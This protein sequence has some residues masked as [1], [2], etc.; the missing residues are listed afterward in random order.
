MAETG[1]ASGSVAEL[2]ELFRKAKSARSG[3]IG[4]WFLNTSYYAGQQWSAYQGGRVIDLHTMSDRDLVTDNRIMPVVTH[5]V[6]RKV[7]NRPT[8]YCTPYTGDDS[9]TEAARIG[10]SVLEA[11]WDQLDLQNKLFRACLWADVCC[12]GFWKIFWDPTVGERGDFLFSNDGQ[13]LYNPQ[14]QTPLR[15]EE[16]H[17]VPPDVLPLTQVQSV[18]DGD[19]VVEV[20]SPFELFPD[21][22]ATGLED[23]E[24]MIEEKIRSVE[25]V[26]QRY[27]TDVNGAAFTPTPDASLP[28]GTQL[29]PVAA[30]SQFSDYS[31]Y[32]GVKVYEYWCKPN[33]EHPNGKRVA[34]INDTKVAEDMNPPDPMPY[35]KFS[36]V[37]VPG[38]FWSQAITTHLRG[39]QEQLNKIRTQVLENA[40][41]LGNLSLL[42]SREANVEYHG[43]PGERVKYSS[44]TMDAKPEFMAP[45][46]IPPYVENEIE[47][48]INSMMEI[49]G[50]HE[51]SRAQ[52]PAGVTAA[53]AINLLQEQDD[54]RIGP[55]ILQMEQSLED[56]GTKIL[57]LR[58]RYNTD[59][60]TIRIA[61]EDGDWDIF[62]FKGA[63]LGQDPQV[64]VQAGSGMP[65]TKAAKQAAMTEILGLVFQY[66]VP[67]D[68]RSLRRFLKAYDAGGLEMLFG[69]LSEDEQQVTREHRRLAKGTVVHINPGID[70]H[71][72]HIQAHQEYQKSNR[73]DALPPPVQQ[74]FTAHVNEHRQFLLQQT[75]LQLA[76]Q[77]RDTQMAAVAEKDR[78]KEIELAKKQADQGASPKQKA[79]SPSSR[80][81]QAGSQVGPG[82]GGGSTR[83]SG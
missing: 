18:A 66:G 12:D 52:V 22:L 44:T 28:E 21:P 77:Q 79:A 4:D 33:A 48:A 71:K 14:D 55:E 78:T 13:P 43:V 58:A 47:R 81:G 19:V 59:E 76:A 2:Q 73:Y 56:A 67:V 1:Y 11:D 68:S 3:Y 7:K 62:A 9:D 38:R 69:N 61:G 82:A 70:D 45:P 30:L 31:G 64:E 49:S 32:E 24:W 16:S 57:K 27:P 20:I 53:S 29:N 23:I 37:Q 50:I 83:N 34:W 65:R 72:F 35:I 6:A 63:M 17:M 15:A 26:K 54:T 40:K 5:R 60:R 10:E 8:F 42:E 41:R 80:N 74:M 46:G 39:P 75:N 25:Y 51:V 36:S